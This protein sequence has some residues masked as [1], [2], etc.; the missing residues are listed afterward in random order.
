LNRGGTGTAGCPLGGPRL[1][2]L[3]DGIED[4][5]L[6]G[7]VAREVF[8]EMWRTGAGADE[9][10]ADKGLAQISDTGELAAVIAEVIANSEKQVAQYRA[11]KEKVF[12]YFV[13]Q[14]M[15]ATQGRANPG[16]V[17]RLLKERLER[18]EKAG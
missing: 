15:K 6:S 1:A 4:G 10:I 2:A 12:G 17:N 3:R 18:Q 8:D 14:V 11:G 13:G 16:E 7:N 9:V 5:T